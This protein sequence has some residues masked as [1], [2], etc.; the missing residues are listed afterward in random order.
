L[1]ADPEYESL[2]EYGRFAFYGGRPEIMAI[3]PVRRPVYQWDINS[4][5]PFAMR[6]LP[7]LL[8]GGW[9]WHETWEG[10]PP[11]ADHLDKTNYAI[12]YGT[13]EGKEGERASWYGLPVRDKNGSISYPRAGKGWYWNFEIEESKHQNFTVESAWVY[14][15]QCDCHPLEYVEELYDLRLQ[16]GK[17]G[18]GGVLKLLLNSKYGKMV[19]SI[20]FPKYANPVWGSFITAF[21][22]GMVQG[23][24]HASPWC[25]RG[26]CGR[27]ILAVATDSVSTWTDRQDLRES[28]RL[29]GWSREVHPD[30]VFQV[31]PGLYFGS[32][33][34][35]VKTRGVPRSVVTTMREEFESKF[36][37]MCETGTL[38]DGDVRVEQDLFVG[39]KYALH[40]KN[41]KLLGQW[42]RFEDED[43]KGGKLIKFDWTTKRKP[44]PVIGPTVGGNSYIETFPYDGD[45]NVSTVP[46]SKDIGGLVAR[47]MIRE[48]FEAQ[49]EWVQDML[50]ED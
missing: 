7:C 44:L 46:Y 28:K 8:H 36:A 27:D 48:W 9:T 4:A 41:L 29:G 23:F 34:K 18:A 16:L 17:D 5:Y 21:C 39:I 24:I 14:T 11:E 35:P 45:T 22:R 13:F 32:S 25:G 26:M 42:V 31:Q 33:G 20:G 1:L 40:R 38:N 2:L 30:G 19:Q 15:R 3:G 47:G 6:Y 37:R 49:P 12:C 50:G 10:A 43:G